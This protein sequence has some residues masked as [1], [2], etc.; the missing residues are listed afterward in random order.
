MVQFISE[1]RRFRHP[2]RLNNRSFWTQ[3]PSIAAV[4]ASMDCHAARYGGTMHTMCEEG[5][6]LRTEAP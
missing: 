6:V 3:R 5:G 2:P 1:C 4:V